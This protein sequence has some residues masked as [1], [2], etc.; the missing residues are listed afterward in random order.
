MIRVF[1]FSL[2][3]WII[4]HT[5]KNPATYYHKR[6][7]VF[8]LSTR[9]ACQVLIKP[10]LPRHIYEKNP[11]LE[12][13]ENPSIGSQGVPSGRTD[14]HDAANSLLF[15][16]LRTCLKI[17][18]MKIRSVKTV[19]PMLCFCWLKAQVSVLVTQWPRFKPLALLK[20]ERS[21]LLTRQT[22]L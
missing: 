7:L 6:I 18:T 15:V 19:T 8:T 21:L 16:I 11:N 14:G 17:I 20:R 10:E 9:H 13:H 1:W 3:L 22:W 4:S 12:F 5:K 2:Q